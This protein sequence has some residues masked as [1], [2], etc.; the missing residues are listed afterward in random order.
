MGSLLQDVYTA[1][2]S[3]YEPVIKVRYP[4]VYD[5]AAVPYIYMYE[6]DD[7]RQKNYLC[8]SDGGQ[9]R[10]TIG[11][12]SESFP[13]CVDTLDSIIDYVRTLYGS[14]TVEVSIVD[15]GNTRDLTGIDESEKMIYRREFDTIFYWS[16]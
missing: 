14:G 15:A 12:L 7:P 13:D 4:Y 2:K 11:Y 6:V 3:H 1:M 8:D 16:K 5:E 10:I 9:S